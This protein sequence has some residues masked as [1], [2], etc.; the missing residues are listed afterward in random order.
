MSGAA[1]G[2]EVGVQGGIEVKA[3]SCFARCEGQLC[4]DQQGQQPV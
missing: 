2:G 4:A 1:A 3:C